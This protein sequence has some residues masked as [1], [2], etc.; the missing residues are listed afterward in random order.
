MSCKSSKCSELASVQVKSIVQK[1][2]FFSHAKQNEK[3]K[4]IF[5]TIAYQGL[6]KYQISFPI[7]KVGERWKFQMSGF[8]VKPLPQTRVFSLMPCRTKKWIIFDTMAC[9]RLL[10]YQISFPLFKVSEPWKFLMSGFCIITG[11]THISKRAF[12]FSHSKQNENYQNESY[13][14]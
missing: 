12:F 3:K 13:L 10:K 4:V 14:T 11:D 9:Q 7:F 1:M 5:G 6:L 2:P 8:E